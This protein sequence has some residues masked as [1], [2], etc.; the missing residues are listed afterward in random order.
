MIERNVYKRYYHNFTLHSQI[1]TLLIILINYVMF[2]IN[3]IY[4]TK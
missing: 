1:K 2:L 3:I 4:T